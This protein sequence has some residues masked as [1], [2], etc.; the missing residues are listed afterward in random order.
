MDDLKRG[1]EFPEYAIRWFT[2]ERGD[3]EESNANPSSEK[4]ES[5]ED[6][7]DDNQHDLD[8]FN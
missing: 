3:N 5:D 8:D 7:E 2:S 4:L 1:L 6:N